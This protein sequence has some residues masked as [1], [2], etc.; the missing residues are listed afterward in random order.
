MGTPTFGLPAIQA[1][2][3]D[4]EFEVTGAVCQP[5]PHGHRRGGSGHAAIK[6]CALQ[7]NLPLF[8]PP[9]LKKGLDLDPFR[10]M[11]LD[12]VVVAAYGK[13]LPRALLDL[14]RLG[15]VNLH[16]SLLPAYR[17]AAPVQRALMAGEKE[18][19]NT[20]MLMSEGLDEGDI[21]ASESFPISPNMTGGELYEA[22]ATAGAPLLI[23]TLKAFAAGL[24]TPRPQDHTRA[25][26]AARITPETGRI[27][28]SRPASEIHNL[29]RAL[30]PAPLTETRLLGTPLK[31]ASSHLPTTPPPGILTGLPPGR[32][33]GFRKGG[34]ALVQCGSGL[35][36]LLRVRPA[37][38]K[39]IS[40]FDLKNGFRLAGGEPL[41]DGS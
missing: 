34:G 36:E 12:F 2:L 17:G 16:G 20:I 40:G 26:Y 30:A 4:P 19:G 39:E 7:M 18:S 41:G 32:L 35:I 5:D 21:L 38:K 6:T 14:P 33:A 8:Q 28:F 24:I 15:C 11:A 27:D 25:T 13:I 23:R 31:I 37:G 29:V 9:S 3:A 10:A 22:L 1:L